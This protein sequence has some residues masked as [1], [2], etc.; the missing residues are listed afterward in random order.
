MFFS[1]FP[2]RATRNKDYK[3][4]SPYQFDAEL[5]RCLQCQKKPCSIGCPC[6]CNPKDFIRAARGGRKSDIDLAAL[7]MYSKT[8]SSSTCGT[9]CSTDFCMYRCSRAKIDSIPVNITAVQS[10]IARRAHI[11]NDGEFLKLIT[12]KE[13]TGK[14]VAVVGAG[15]AGLS[16]AACL[17]SRGH[18]VV[19]YEKNPS[20]GGDINYIPQFRRPFFKDKTIS[21]VDLDAKFT[22]S[23]G[24]VTFKYNT[25]FPIPL[26][27]SGQL[28]AEAENLIKQYNAVCWCVGEQIDNTLDI[29]GGEKAINGRQFLKLSPKDVKNK[30]VMVIGCGAVAIDCAIFATKYGSKT[31]RIIYRR[32][33]KEAPLSSDE[34]GLISSF[35]VSVIPLT[36]VSSLESNNQNN[37]I[38]MNTIQVSLP[39]LKPVEGT[40][41]KWKDVDYV[42]FAIGQKS[43]LPSVFIKKSNEDNKND[44]IFQ[45]IGGTALDVKGSMLAVEA[46]ASGK[47][48]AMQIDA[49]L[50]G[51][52]IPEI[53]NPKKSNYPVF[54]VNFLP[55]KL[56]VSVSFDGKNS[57]QIPNPFV[58]AASPFTDNFNAV[59]NLLKNGWAGVVMNVSSSPHHIRNYQRKPN[60]NYSDHI[61]DRLYKPGYD[62][63]GELNAENVKDIVSKLRNKYPNR[64]FI[65]SLDSNSPTFEK[66]IQLLNDCPLDAIQIESNGKQIQV[67]SSHPIL[68]TISIEQSQTDNSQF[69]VVDIIRHYPSNKAV[70]ID[71]NM[72]SM[73]RLL[74]VRQ[75]KLHG[76][77]AVCGGIKNDSDALFYLSNGAQFV[78][79]DPSSIE[80]NGLG[81]D[82]MT[83]MMSHF[84]YSQKFNSL[85][86]FINQKASIKDLD[87]EDIQT[88]DS[89]QNKS[90][91]RLICKLTNP[92]VCLGCGRCIVCP[93]DAI[94]LEPAKWK[95]VVDPDKCVGCG[96]CV[97]KCPTEAISLVKR[98]ENE[99]SHH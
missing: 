25:E 90:S 42:V 51:Q 39:D 37:T 59:N 93:N 13:P 80:N 22:L 50:N 74:P 58:A 91:E 68:S 44:S 41:Q 63:V 94:D 17:A 57:I 6:N 35:G 88:I 2:S 46:C 87:I 48:A 34:Y 29:P 92:Y 56:D 20:P 79:V 3:C 14:T 24:D 66:D 4:L 26:P 76:G 54:E 5:S 31:T 10:E 8:P 23:C 53:E 69:A 64:L 9:L 21:T 71:E 84:I 75:E 96:L 86:E 52:P 40:E 60:E 12:K 65:A 61:N 77:F 11:D 16:C 38:T 27:E 47:N 73:H 98:D 30:N 36:V 82:M 45:F 28:N 19:I 43:E 15:P 70:V 62:F 81:I 1:V 7:I 83:A 85:Q 89:L 72:Q 99:D 67:N 49:F 55:S 33:L 32:T 97:S 78:E 95:Y 18:K